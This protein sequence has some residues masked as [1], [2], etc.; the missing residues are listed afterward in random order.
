MKVYNSLVHLHFD[1]CKVVRRNCNK[2][3][4]DKLRQ[5]LY[6]RAACIFLSSSYGSNLH[7]AFRTLWW[8]K[9]SYQRLH[10]K[11]IMIYIT[12]QVILSF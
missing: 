4:A 2:G 10:K 7:Y 9:L 12:T 6:N 1:Y 11:S 8:R 5:T 3:L